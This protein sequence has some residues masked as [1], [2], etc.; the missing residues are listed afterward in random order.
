MT[1]SVDLKILPIFQ[2]DGEALADMP[3][4]HVA[5][6]P[7][8][9]ARRRSGEQYILH[10][11][12]SG[13]AP[14][15]PT[16]LRQIKNKLSQV[17][18]KT[19]G[20]TTSALREVAEVL[21]QYLHDRNLRGSS[22]GIRGIGILTQMVLRGNTLFLA[23]SGGSHVYFITADGV[24]ELYDIDLAGPG[25]GAGRV[26]KVRYY[27]EK[28]SEDDLVL[29]TPQPPAAWS[30]TT[31]KNLSRMN[32]KSIY[33]RLLFRVEDD[34]NAILFLPEPG[35]GRVKVLQPVFGEGERDKGLD[36]EAAGEGERQG[37]PWDPIKSIPDLVSP[38]GAEEV[39]GAEER[40]IR[41]EPGADYSTHE[42][43]MTEEAVGPDQD[44]GKK[45]SEMLRKFM[46]L[47]VWAYLGSMF[48][49]VGNGL[50]AIWDS[51]STLL[52]RMLPDERYLDFPG[53]V[54]GLIAVLVPI[55]IVVFGSVIYVYRGRN[56]LYEATYLD[57]KELVESAEAIEN[58]EE[59]HQALVKALES[60]QE[61]RGYR[62]TEE[63]ERLYSRVRSELDELDRITRL[64]Y[65]PLFSH[66]LGADVK[67]SEI[68]VTAWNDLYMLNENDGTVIWAQ[69]NAD[70]YEI[71]GA[72]HCGPI[73]GHKTVGPL[74]DIV[75]LPASGEDE[76]TIL[77]IDQS[78][79]MIFC[80]PNPDESPVM[81]E[82]S[83][84]TL[85]RGPVEAMTI[86][87]NSPR[88]LYILDPEKRAIWIEFQS[89][90]YHEGSEYFGATDSPP[91]NDAIDLATNG[92]ELYLLHAD[93]YI[94]KCVTE[95]PTSDPQCQTPFEYS[96]P[97]PGYPSGPFVSGA[98]FDS[99]KFKGSPGMAIYMLDPEHQAIYR[100]STQ[101]EY[102]RQFRPS[103]EDLGEGVTAFT[104]T[105]SDR[106]YLAVGSQVYTAQLIP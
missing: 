35:E 89:Q 56:T 49:S 104:V 25:L 99:I 71:K 67:I 77:G 2:K 41:E 58:P 96:D 100:F 11:S 34:L 72:F 21:N 7:R 44:P 39:G 3:A 28:I 19:E 32:L 48:R 73:T 42:E 75:P 1:N 66:G 40:S 12:L 87:T 62:E 47:P 90:N 88:N 95:S 94:S 102:Q 52:G 43:E 79:T 101:M 22:R 105:M 83:S 14:L 50:R 78:H 98:Q 93:G 24:K 17:F 61:A 97:R 103:G 15:S 20:S 8:K 64:E 68:V 45:R 53:W 6:P 37:K 69:S 13:N 26:P 65:D 29:I 27:Q 63:V 18:Y 76:A 30:K 59:H 38:S 81:F 60:I 9:A 106:V 84:Y 86:S 10:L 74:V 51:F 33:H 46:D 54:L 85:D 55:L 23:Q 91:M 31:L 92:S 4:L 82:D 36:I 16:S 5:S 80:Y 57:A 70:G